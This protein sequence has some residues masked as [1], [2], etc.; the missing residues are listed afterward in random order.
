MALYGTLVLW[1]HYNRQANMESL[2]E[3]SRRGFFYAQMEVMCVGY[4][5][6]SYMEQIWYILRYKLQQLFRKEDKRAK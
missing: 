2:Y 3:Q 6:V 4:R 5:K 1:Y